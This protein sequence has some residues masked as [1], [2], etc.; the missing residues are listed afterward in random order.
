MTDTDFKLLIHLY[1]DFIFAR[2]RKKKDIN[3][4]SRDIKD[5]DL[6]WL[7]GHACPKE[8][9]VPG[10]SLVLRVG[11]EGECSSRDLQEERKAPLWPLGVVIAR[12]DDGVPHSVGPKFHRSLRVGILRQ[13]TRDCLISS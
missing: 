4:I 1:L 5:R 10:L 2:E 3:N 9:L 6:T 8:C 12:Q 7:P 13:N 11:D